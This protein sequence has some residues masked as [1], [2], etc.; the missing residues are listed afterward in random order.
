MVRD[1]AQ[2][3]HKSRG[4]SM[5]KVSKTFLVFVVCVSL[6]IPVIA[7]ERPDD[8]TTG[9]PLSDESLGQT[10]G[11]RTGQAD[12]RLEWQRQAWGVVTPAFR[13]HAMKEGKNHSDKK[14]APGPKWVNIGP[15][16]A[17]YEQNGSFTG[18]VRDSGRARTI[19]PHPTNAD[20][21]YFLTSGGGL[22]RTNNWTSPQ[23]G[24]D[25]AHR[26]PA[27]HRRRLGGVRQEPEHA[28]PR[29]RR[30]VRS[31]P[32]RRLDGEVEERRQQLVADDRARHRR[33][34]A[35]RQGRHQHQSRHRPRGDEQR[36]VPLGR[37]RR[38]VRRRSDVRR[39]VRLE[40]R[41]H[42]RGLARF[43][44]AV[45]GRERRPAVRPGDHA[46]PL[47][48]SRRDVGADHERRQRLLRSTAARR[49]ASPCRA[50]AWSTPT[51]ARQTDAADARR[52]PL[53]GRRPDL[54]RQ[55]RQLDQDP[56]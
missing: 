46:L 23:H 18:H 22:W 36:P 54:G 28:L 20:I 31:D 26:R 24:V 38:H 3:Q 2:T 56:D 51:R 40:H 48:R 7:Q 8:S 44:A 14:N 35:R 1:L 55:R 4:G 27:D 42:E 19:L 16:G 10:A 12:A 53:G 34:R 50:T 33:L 6:I 17:D 29:P 45:S 41:A 21:V 11:R 25:A 5:R 37:R 9:I 47:D 13:S 15:T 52:L 32:R 39:H 43:G 30:S 49:S